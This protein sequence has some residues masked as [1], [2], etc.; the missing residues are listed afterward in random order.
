MDKLVY[1]SVE[2]RLE[3]ALNGQAVAGG[4]MIFFRGVHPCDPELM[5]GV[6]FFLFT[7]HGSNIYDSELMTFGDLTTLS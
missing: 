6:I 4:E 5:Y 7:H 2:L 1:H 3:V